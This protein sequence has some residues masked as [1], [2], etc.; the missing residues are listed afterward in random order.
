MR[1]PLLAYG[2]LL[3]ICHAMSATDLVC[4]ISLLLYPH[5][6]RQCP[7]LSCCML[8]PARS[9][10][11][12]A[13]SS[14]RLYTSHGIGLSAYALAMRCPVLTS[15]MSG[16]DVPSATTSVSFS[17]PPGT[18]S[19]TPLRACY[20]MS[21]TD[22]GYAATSEL[23]RLKSISESPVISHFSSS[24]QGSAVVRAMGS[25]QTRYLPTYA[26]LCNVRYWG[27]IVYVLGV[28]DPVRT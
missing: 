2:I 28:H 21:G 13:P 9:H 14:L 27:P 17:V 4:S 23:Q 25:Y 24:A 3:R 10:T 8:L 6:P 16:T 12:Y 20:A 1:Y 19:A 11:S 7:V 15:R 18:I 26:Q 22:I 5:R